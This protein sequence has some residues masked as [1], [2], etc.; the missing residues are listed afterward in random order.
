MFLIILRHLLSYFNLVSSATCL[1]NSHVHF[2]SLQEQDKQNQKT[3][4]RRMLNESVNKPDSAT[5]K[6]NQYQ[7]RNLLFTVQGTLYIEWWLGFLAIASLYNFHIRKTSDVELQI[8]V[9]R[10]FKQIVNIVMA[11]SC[12]FHYLLR[13]IIVVFAF[14]HDNLERRMKIN[15]SYRISSK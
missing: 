11:S 9:C 13:S 8:N 5:L 4:W 12:H 1:I 15:I 3:Y 6:V 2:R 10:P 14:S 7:R